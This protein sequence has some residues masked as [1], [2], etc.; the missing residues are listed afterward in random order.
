MTNRLIVGCGYVGQRVARIWRN[1]GDV[2][3][4]I[5]RT[6]A[7]AVDLRRFGIVPIVW[8]WLAGGPVQPGLEMQA[9]SSASRIELETILISV[10]HSPQ[11]GVESSETHTKGLKNLLALL[12]SSQFD[13]T[14]A[15]WIYLSTTGV[16]GPS[17]PGGW[18]DEESTVSPER[19][20]SIAAY[21]GEQWI[22]ENII[23]SKRVVMRPVGIYGPDRVP[24]WQSIRDQVPL[25][26][27][28]DSYLNLIHV[29]DL[30]T[31]IRSVSDMSMNRT[32]YCVSDGSPVVRREYYE[33]IAKLGNWPA[34]IFDTDYVN[35]MERSRTRSD[36]NKRV[37]NTLIQS[38]LGLP[39]LFP[40]FREGLSSLL[41]PQ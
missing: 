16:F 37:R 17:T 26:A 6:E 12:P 3:Y 22:S 14:H 8:D 40:S 4:A 36:G 1:Q 13:A 38:E 11:P 33:F 7:R 29:D 35:S 28:P 20:G 32:L 31:I 23:E 39:L 15:K 19:P 10:S 27:D 30:A 25:Q 5:T 9:I 21:A 18:V 2:V 34:P 24:R 41:A